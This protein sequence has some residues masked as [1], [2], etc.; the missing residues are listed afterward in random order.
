M[1]T[2]VTLVPF[3]QFFK[4]G[5]MPGSSY[6]VVPDVRQFK[7]LCSDLD[8]G[9]QLRV[10]QALG[11]MLGIHS[12]QSLRLTGD[13]YATHPIEVATSLITDFGCRDSNLIIMALLH[14][15]VE[16]QSRKLAGFTSDGHDSRL[17]AVSVIELLFED[18]SESG[19]YIAT[20]VKALSNQE[21]LPDD[22]RT[23]VQ[24]Y[25]DHIKTLFHRYPEIALV[26]CADIKQNAFRL[27]EI[28]DFPS[29]ISRARKYKPA[30]EFIRTQIELYK[31]IK[32]HPLSAAAAKFLPELEQQLRT[33]D[34]RFPASDEDTG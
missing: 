29:C 16:D 12:D 15:T 25:L 11:M 4:V 14:D 30:L 24:R 8:L 3:R 7:A 31:D 33:W 1:L 34:E 9:D 32:S 5:I 17:N 21:P 13:H 20:G 6:F 19:S 2:F 18:D 22:T 23:K 28:S 26:K 10:M 27:D